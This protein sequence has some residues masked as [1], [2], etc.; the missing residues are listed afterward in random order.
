LTRET[1]RAGRFPC[2]VH[3]AGR[4]TGD[5]L[6]ISE[7]AT[8]KWTH[9]MTCYA[10]CEAEDV[11]A[12]LGMTWQDLAREPSVPTG[13]SR[14]VPPPIA[15]PPPPRSTTGEPIDAEVW[16]AKCRELVLTERRRIEKLQPFW[17][18]NP[19][20]DAIKSK[21]RLIATL[22]AELGAQ[23]ET[24]EMWDG[25]ALLARW[26]T[27]VNQ[28]EA[29]LDAE[30]ARLRRPPPDTPEFRAFERL[31]EIGWPN[32]EWNDMTQEAR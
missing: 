7:R 28:D 10:G 27:E 16:A 6:Q 20:L 18:L 21:R 17:D 23:G 32:D 13:S 22:R 1:F 14:W 9:R 29:E 4:A 15:V 25:M 31:V 5:T 8:G 19:R 24:A 2:P 3:Q 30:M 26:E 11:L 12:A